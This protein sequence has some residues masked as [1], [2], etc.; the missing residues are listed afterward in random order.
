MHERQQLIG[1]AEEVAEVGGERT[2]EQEIALQTL[3]RTLM[4]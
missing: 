2:K 3:R 1:M 4:N